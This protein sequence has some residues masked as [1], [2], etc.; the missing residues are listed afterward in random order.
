MTQRERFVN[1][2]LFQPVDRIPNF[3]YGYM[4]GVLESWQEQGLPQPVTFDDLDD[5]FGLDVRRQHCV[6]P[7]N[8]SAPVPAFPEEILEEDE[9][10]AVKSF[11]DGVVRRYLRSAPYVQQ[12]L[13]FPLKTQNDFAAL[14]ARFDPRSPERYPPAWK[15]MVVGHRARGL[16]L[17]LELDG[18]FHR[19]R[20]WLGFEE[21][22]MGYHLRPA[23]MHAIADFWTQF[24]LAIVEQ[25]LAECHLDFVQFFEDMAFKTGPMVSPQLFATFIM[26]YYQRLVG[27]IRAQ[28]VPLV[29]FDSDGRINEL[30][31]LIIECDFDGLYPLEIAA[32][33]RPEGLQQQFGERLGLLGGID[34]RVLLAGPSEIEKELRAKVP[35]LT[36]R[37]GYVPTI[38]HRVPLGT[39]LDNWR[40]YLKLKNELLQGRS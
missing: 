33:V 28:G 13:S 22:C 15:E 10:T 12:E 30:V 34:K 32:G 18:F 19:A 29:L 36:R 40:Y 1:T 7:V 4:D 6:V 24:N 2:L 38:D 3:E 21:A 35:A 25:V 11:A 27:F 8:T 16:P 5:C 14:G 23:L 39:S 37:G 9:N 17:G 20:L 31:P 26:P